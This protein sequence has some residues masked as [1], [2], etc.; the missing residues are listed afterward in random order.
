MDS[1][2]AELLHA[3]SQAQALFDQVIND[4][5]I[6]AGVTESRLSEEIGDLA[7]Q[8]FGVRRH[9]HKRV[10]RS[11]VNTVLGYYDDPPDRHLA[12]GDTVYLDFGP[13]FAEWEAD[14]GRTYVLGND[15][16]KQSLVDD[17]A[18]IFTDGKQLYRRTPAL[19][20]GGLYDFVAQRALD[21]GWEFGAKTAGHLVGRFPHEHAPGAPT[22]FSIRHGNDLLLREPD[23]NGNSRH[24][25]LE[26][27]L[28]DRERTFGGFFE[29]LL[30][31]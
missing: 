29:E 11:G 17:L 30:T 6:R 2:A 23:A 12:D 31:V 26:V 1:V 10:V 21:S 7:A 18:A 25:I 15:P 9:W 20:A 16:R 3:Q 24:W 27:H 14:F 28:V 8:R 19:T 4:G 22:R 5:L 13:I